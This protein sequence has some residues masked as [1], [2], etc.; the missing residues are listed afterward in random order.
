MAK[1]KKRRKINYAKIFEYQKS[2][3]L[4]KSKPP[5]TIR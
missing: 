1:G 2:I 3:Y 4:P 5:S